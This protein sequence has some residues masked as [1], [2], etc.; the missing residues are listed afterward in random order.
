[1]PTER[2]TTRPRRIDPDATAGDLDDAASPPWDEEEQQE[3]KPR[4]APAR[5]RREPEAP[6]EPPRRRRAQQRQVEVVDEDEDTPAVGGDTVLPRIIRGKDAVRKRLSQKD[7]S[8]FFKWPEGGDE[9]VVKF[10]DEDPWAYDQHWVT[11]GGKQSFA[12]IGRDNGC[13]FCE[14]GSQPS[15]RY[16]YQILNLSLPDPLVQGLEV[17]PTQATDLDA[18]DEDRK[19]GPLPRMWWG[20][21]RT[22]LAKPKGLQKYQYLIR[23]I[24]DRDLE[25]DYEITLDWAEDAVAAAVPLKDDQYFGG[26]SM[27]EMRAI[28][29]EVMGGGTGS[30]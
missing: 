7:G 20:L 26:L 18:F 2:T 3:E 24:K 10:L 22:K 11:R 23:P 19:T 16:V 29:R 28:A 27:Q 4:R 9:A 14:I 5:S 17:G 1:M 12:C 15:G 8:I 13:P 25:D 30:R 6:V 21:S